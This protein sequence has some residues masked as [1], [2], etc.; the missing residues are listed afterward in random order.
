MIDRE[1]AVGPCGGFK[2][3]ASYSHENDETSTLAKVQAFTTQGGYS[4]F[5]AIPET[6]NLGRSLIAAA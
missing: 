4:A 6:R 2:L 1:G 5:A 3:R